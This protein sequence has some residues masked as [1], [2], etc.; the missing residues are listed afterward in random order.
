M[1]RGRARHGS[2]MAA[3]LILGTALFAG[4]A[5]APT[6]QPLSA[7]VAREPRPYLFLLCMLA[8]NELATAAMVAIQELEAY[9]NADGA[10][11]VAALVQL[12]GGEQRGYL[13][14]PQGSGFG[15]IRSPQL[16]LSRQDLYSAAGL[17]TQV[18][19]IQRLAPATET[20]LVLWGHGRS[21]RG[22]GAAD[23]TDRMLNGGAIA[24]TLQETGVRTIVLDGGWSAHLELLYEI[25]AQT[26]DTFTALAIAGHL[27][28]AGISY[29]GAL[30]A[31]DQRGWSPTGIIAALQAEYQR[32]VAEPAA[33]LVYATRE[34]IIAT[35]SALDDAARGVGPLTWES[36]RPLRE[37]LN[38]AA[39]LHPTT[40]GV[41][42]SV[43]LSAIFAAL[44]T[45]PLERGAAELGS[46]H[47]Y[48]LSTDTLGFALRHGRDYS[49]TAPGETVPL[50]SLR[51]GWAP[52]FIQQ[53]GLLYELWYRP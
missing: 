15:D 45:P 4:C 2:A 41:D 40:T 32:I 49:S 12:P 42:L 13:I 10:V 44:E 16:T 52:N 50:L 19:A 17:V 18:R 53:T 51:V 28:A 3:V 30:E 38:A 47:L 22:I 1:S 26:P 6:E 46:A 25:A 37:A 35:A 21:W 34:Q 14:Q 36:A 23:P 33:A 20:V 7:A 48:Y 11:H 27:P 8:E 43:S 24:Q 5:F 29:A 31:I 39:I 9:R